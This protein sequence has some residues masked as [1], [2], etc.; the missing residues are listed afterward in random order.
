MDASKFASLACSMILSVAACAAHAQDAA[1][2]AQQA[3]VSRA[4]VQADLQL[5]L[6]SGMA[7]FTY[8]EASAD[9]TNP[10]YREAEAR[11]LAMRSSPEYSQ[12]VARIARGEPNPGQ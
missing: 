7:A 2:S 5:W 12:L 6:K 9:P 8:G 1:S 10:R 3:P 4:E 11:Y